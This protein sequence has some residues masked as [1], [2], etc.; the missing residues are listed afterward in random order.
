MLSYRG[1]EETLKISDA[2]KRLGSAEDEVAMFRPFQEIA[3]AS[4]LSHQTVNPVSQ[5]GLCPR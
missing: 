2:A 4:P 3:E 1:E 5:E